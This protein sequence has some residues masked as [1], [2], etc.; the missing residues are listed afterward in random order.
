LLIVISQDKYLKNSPLIIYLK[1][2]KIMINYTNAQFRSILLGLGFLL[3]DFV[4]ISKG[5]P[6]STDNS[7]LTG[8]KTR[9]TILAFQEKYQINADGIVGPQTRTKA[10][11]VMRIL[12]HQLNIVVD[13]GFTL[14]E[15]FYGPKTVASVK[16]FQA[17]LGLTQNGVATQ[18]L[19]E[20][21]N[22]IAQATV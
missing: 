19:R 12:Q 17:A 6:V 5:Y 8:T 16:K 2:R 14:E 3:K 9:L 13:A 21:L 18:A 20:E 15:P 11:E 4:D 10:V 22:E 7:P 1:G